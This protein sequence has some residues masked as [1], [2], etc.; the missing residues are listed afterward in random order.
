[1]SCAVLS[2]PFWFW[3]SDWRCGCTYVIRTRCGCLQ[4]RP[5]SASPPCCLRRIWRPW[6]CQR[7]AKQQKTNPGEFGTWWPTSSLRLAPHALFESVNLSW[8]IEACLQFLKACLCQKVFCLSPVIPSG[9]FTGFTIRSRIGYV[10]A[11]VEL[12]LLMVLSWLFQ[13]WWWIK[14]SSYWSFRC[15][16]FTWACILQSLPL[17]SAHGF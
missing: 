4:W 13:T 6:W 17:F 15:D 8:T 10:L 12:S 2:C 1:M 14:I 16:G 11:V 5:V 3:T 7:C 9:S